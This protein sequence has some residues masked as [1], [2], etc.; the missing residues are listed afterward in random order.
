MN[1][2]KRGLFT[3]L[4]ALIGGFI[5]LWAYTRYFDDPKIVTMQ[6]DP[7]MRYASLPTSY[8]GDLPDLTFAAENSVHAVV[9]IT[10]TQKGGYYSSNNIFDW[11]FGEGGNRPQQMPIR[12]GVGSGVIISSDGL[13]VTNNHVVDEADEITVVL[14]DKREF[15]AKLVGTDPSTDIALVKIDASDLPVLKFSNSDN[16][17]LGEW[18][19]AVGNPFNLTSTVTAGIVSAKGRDI[20]INPDQ[21]RIESFIQ[22]DAAVNPGNSGGALVNI[23][24]ELVGINTAIA[25]Q[26]GSYSGYS[27]AIPSNIVQKVV[28]DLGKYGEVQRALLNVNIQDVD[29]KVAKENNLDKIE[30]VFIGSANPG[31]AA[32]LAGIKDKDIIISIDG[33]NVNSTGELQEQINMHKPG[34][35]IVVVVKRDNKRKPLNV[36]LRNKHGDTQIVKGDNPDDIFGAKFVTASDRDKD[37]LGIRYG[38]KISELGNGKFKDAGIKKG[39][40][41]TQVNKSVISG[42]DDLVR[43]IKNARGGILVEG[44]YPN[45]E[46]AYYVFGTNSK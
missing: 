29:A 12:Q 24:G 7:S 1:N 4:V 27:F 37:E 30:G 42:V 15:K 26:T 19:L 16:L 39:F 11:F 38:V 18:V 45:G 32:E 3:L 22:T 8:S 13:I 28:A 31:G 25:S 44:I 40:I 17:K 23:R 36:T 5:A 35:K 41:I 43:I 21:M 34:D 6:Q 2:I 46:V 33:V 14:N 9:H 20:Q 10:V